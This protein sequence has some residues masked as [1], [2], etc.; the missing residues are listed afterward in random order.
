MHARQGRPWSPAGAF[1]KPSAPEAGARVRRKW[2]DDLAFFDLSSPTDTQAFGVRCSTLACFGGSATLETP[3]ALT[4]ARLEGDCSIGHLSYL[5]RGT[6]LTKAVVGRYC[7]IAPRVEIGPSEHPTDWLSVHPFQYGGTRHF[8]GD[9]AYDGI[10]GPSRY[11]GNEAATVIGN[12]VWIGEGAFIRK[13]V[14]IGDGAVVAARAVVAGDVAPYS[15]VAGVPARPVRWRFDAPT[16]A[17]LLEL[18][19]WRYDLSGVGGRV[20]Y[21]DVPRALETLRGLVERG[22]LALLQPRVVRVHGGR[23]VRLETLQ[24]GRSAPA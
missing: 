11:A 23:T 17:A 15:V 14:R 3:V 6:T 16:V 24:E 7:A 1:A 2:S 10:V 20:D 4:A 12:D 5:G 9:P 19:W 8:L 13:G 18:Q 21:S 22:E